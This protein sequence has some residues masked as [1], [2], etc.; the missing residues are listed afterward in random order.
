MKPEAISK[1]V[2]AVI[3]RAEDNLPQGKANIVSVFVK[4]TMGSPV[5]IL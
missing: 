3:K 5:R 1:N 4:T 2:E